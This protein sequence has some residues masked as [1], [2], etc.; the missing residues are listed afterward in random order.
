MITVDNINHNNM[1]TSVVAVVG[2]VLPMVTSMVIVEST[3]EFFCRFYKDAYLIS[4]YSN[5]PSE[6]PKKKTNGF[7]GSLY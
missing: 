5:Q 6:G 3:T 4:T 1:G 2:Q 7:A